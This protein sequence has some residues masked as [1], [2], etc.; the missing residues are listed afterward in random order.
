MA[1]VDR[2][3]EDVV[4]VPCGYGPSLAESLAGHTEL[5][6][7]DTLYVVD[8][9]FPP[10]ELA[11]LWESGIYVAMYDHHQTAFDQWKPWLGDPNA[12]TVLRHVQPGKAVVLIDLGRSGAG[13]AWDELHQRRPVLIDYIED[14]DLWRFELPNSERISP[15]LLAIPHEVDAWQIALC[16][17]VDELK[18]LG[19]GAEAFQDRAIAELLTRP[20][21]VEFGG[22][23]FPI[24]E[25]PYILG[26][27]ACDRLMRQEDTDMAGYWLISWSGDYQYGFRSRNGVTVNDFAEQFGGGGHPQASG[28]R[29]KSPLHVLP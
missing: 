7:G 20:T 25:S 29:S 6:S 17:T 15:Y 16:R 19:E 18:T 12:E 9:S 1:V 13:I 22:R 14:R 11:L 10:E 27:T 2:Y 4:L 28:C 21:W 26:S 8:F 5:E 23:R 3:G 24:V